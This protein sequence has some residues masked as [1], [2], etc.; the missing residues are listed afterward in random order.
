MQAGHLQIE[1]SLADDR[2]KFG[3]PRVNHRLKRLVCIGD[4]GFITLSALRGFAE[5]ISSRVLDI[6]LEPNRYPQLCIV[7]ALL[8]AARHNFMLSQRL[9]H[10]IAEQGDRSEISDI[11]D[12]QLDH[13]GLVQLRPHDIA[14]RLTDTESQLVTAREQ[15]RLPNF[16]DWKIA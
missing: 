6:N 1:D 5:A 13:Y 16:E 11:V 3:L 15:L 14:K 12:A 7:P 2:Y 9:G 4:D 10:Y 8:T